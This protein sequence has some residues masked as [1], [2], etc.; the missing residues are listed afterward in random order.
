MEKFEAILP[1]FFC[2]MYCLGGEGPENEASCMYITYWQSRA[3]EKIG[4]GGGG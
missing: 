2:I 3:A 4:G 1:S